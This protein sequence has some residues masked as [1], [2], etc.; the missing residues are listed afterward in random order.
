MFQLRSIFIIF[1]IFLLQYSQGQDANC[2]F[3]QNVTVGRTYYVYS[4]RY[5]SNYPAGV[6]CR[7]IANCPP[8]YNC[9][10]DCTDVDLPASPSCSVD[11]LLIS[12]TGDPQL[13][14]A[15]YYCGRGSVTAVSTAQRLSIGLIISARS[16]GGRFMC[17]LTAQADNTANQCSCGYKKRNRIVGGQ[18]TYPNEY[19]MMAGLVYVSQRQIRCGAVIIDRRYVLTA[20]HCVVNKMVSDLAVIVGEHNVSTGGDS[21]ATQGFRVSS[22]IVHPQFNPSTFDYDIAIVNL[23]GMITFS[24]YVGPVCLPFKYANRDFAGSKVTLL[25]WGTQM[26]GGET[27]DVLRKV[28]VEV[29]SQASCQRAV[30]SL[31]PRQMCTYTPGKDACQDD[32]GGPALFTDPT[33]GLLFNIGII[34]FGRLCATAGDPGV[35]TRV[36]A[37]LDWIVMNAPADYCRK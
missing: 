30:T 5:P 37:L 25:G 32:S 15:D 24:E 18:E 21:P 8:G 31:T 23:V 29:I 33:T 4:P 10:V 7:W 9:R 14:A 34:S 26:T 20:A 12:K 2:D 35:N 17:T 1:L 22:Y 16:P 28:D 13:T 19:P 36:T 3:Q 11:R 6:Q 27:S